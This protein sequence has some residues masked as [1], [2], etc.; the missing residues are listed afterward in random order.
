MRHFKSMQVVIA[1]INP[2][3]SRGSENR[4]Q[5]GGNRRLLGLPSVVVLAGSIRV[6]AP[7]FLGVYFS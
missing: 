1:K 7:P 5:G 6:I 2:A 4:I 3:Q